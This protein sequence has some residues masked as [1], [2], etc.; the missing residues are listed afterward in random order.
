MSRDYT[1]TGEEKYMLPVAEQ[2]ILCKFKLPKIQSFGSRSRRAEDCPWVKLQKYTIKQLK[3]K[4]QIDVNDPNSLVKSISQVV[5]H[6][7]DAETLNK[8]VIK[9]IPRHITYVTN[10]DRMFANTYAMISLN[11]SPCVSDSECIEPGYVYIRK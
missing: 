11:E 10:G 6:K 7:T 9:W 1:V 2:D 5:L 3:R 8:E 4:K